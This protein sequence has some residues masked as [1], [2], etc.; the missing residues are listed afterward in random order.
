M[1]SISTERMISKTWKYKHF[2]RHAGPTGVH[3][4]I[5][6]G[7]TVAVLLWTVPVDEC[8][9]YLHVKWQKIV[10]KLNFVDL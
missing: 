2:K 8:D 9:E 6:A 5:R 10:L 7:P 3:L 1:K 4:N